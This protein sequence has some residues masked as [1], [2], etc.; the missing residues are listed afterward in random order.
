MDGYLIDSHHNEEY[1]RICVDSPDNEWMHSLD[2]TQRIK[3][4]IEY[5]EKAEPPETTI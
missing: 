3:D 4:L 5:Y 2:E 1:A